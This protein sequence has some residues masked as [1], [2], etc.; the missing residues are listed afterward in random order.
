MTTEDI[1]QS[2][3]NNLIHLTD[4]IDLIDNEDDV[5][6]LCQSYIQCCSS[7]ISN[8]LNSVSDIKTTKAE[9]ALLHCTATWLKTITSH[10][11]EECER[12]EELRSKEKLSPWKHLHAD[13]D[14][15][16]DA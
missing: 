14:L 16:L 3:Q 8:D 1:I 6:T 11:M 12:I 15:L 4:N 2:I 9:L 10:Y 13:Q 7:P 5:I